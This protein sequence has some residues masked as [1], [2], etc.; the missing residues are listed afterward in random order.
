MTD[1]ST[2]PAVVCVG[3][4]V[5]LDTCWHAREA[6]PAAARVDFADSGDLARS[7]AF[8]DLFPCKKCKPVSRLAW[9]EHT[10]R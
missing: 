7:I 6:G 1:I 4:T 10:H 8:T 5:H 9:W 3:T 2:R